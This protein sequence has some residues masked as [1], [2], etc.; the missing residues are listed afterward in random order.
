MRIF[1]KNKLKKSSNLTGYYSFLICFQF[2][3][4]KYLTHISHQ[5]LDDTPWNELEVLP[6]VF[7]PEAWLWVGS[8]LSLSD[9]HFVEQV[10]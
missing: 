2:F 10:E 6:E 3:W 4:L 5:R 9:W 1:F 8:S 7:V